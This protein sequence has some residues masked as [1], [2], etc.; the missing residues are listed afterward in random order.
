MIVVEEQF[1]IFEE[2]SIEQYPKRSPYDLFSGFLAKVS[3]YAME[4][5]P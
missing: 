2:A 1:L 5:R 4:V 3:I